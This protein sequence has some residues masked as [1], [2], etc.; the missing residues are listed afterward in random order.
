MIQNEN[1]Y[2]AIIKD[3]IANIW[4]SVDWRLIKA[5]IKQESGFMLNAR[6]HAGACGLMQL[7]PKTYTELGATAANIFDPVVNIKCGVQYLRSV[8][9][10]FKAESGDER[11]KFALGAYNCGQKYILEAQELGVAQ[12][13]PSDQWDTIVKM[14]PHV[15]DV[16]Y[17]EPIEY[18]D[19]IMKYWKQYRKE[20]S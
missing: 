20:V 12:G 10:I 8:F 14:L 16:R 19:H 11:L 9:L 6:S 3:V 2:D 5:Q 13:L 1:A 17:E 15:P 4:P 18:V 7:M